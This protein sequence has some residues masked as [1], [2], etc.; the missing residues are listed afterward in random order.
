[1][2][3]V[4][5]LEPDDE[6][7]GFNV[8]VPALPGC[9]TQGETVEQAIERAKDAIAIYLDGETADSLHSASVGASVLVEVVEVDAPLPV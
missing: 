1:M 5:G 6:V 3:F 9:F 8:T 2:R 7:G 4:V